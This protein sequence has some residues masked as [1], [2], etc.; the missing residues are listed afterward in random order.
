M[1]GTE[2][3][4]IQAQLGVSNITLAKWLGRSV[5]TIS[6]YRAEPDNKLWSPIPRAEAML[7]AMLAAGEL[8]ERMMP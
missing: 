1:T 8:P 7:F 5:G 2:L 6:S 3:R 4:M